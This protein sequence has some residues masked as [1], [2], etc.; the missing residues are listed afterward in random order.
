MGKKD[1]RMAVS[2]E[3][4]NGI[5]YLKM[6]GWENAF[7]QKVDNFNEGR[8]LLNAPIDIKSS[9]WR[10]GIIQEKGYFGQSHNLIL[11]AHSKLDNNRD[12]WHIH[13]HWS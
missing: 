1:E 10:I 7:L 4:L 2:T 11:G 3:I 8:H 9:R 12:I 6:S 13:L 5:K